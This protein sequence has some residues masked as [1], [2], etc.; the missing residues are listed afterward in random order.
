M[1]EKELC[2]LV[3]PFVLSQPRTQEEVEHFLMVEKN[4]SKEKCELIC[5]RLKDWF[6]SLE[7]RK[8][9]ATATEKKKD[10]ELEVKVQERSKRK[11]NDDNKEEDLHLSPFSKKPRYIN[12]DEHLLLREFLGEKETDFLSKIREGRMGLI[13]VIHGFSGSSGSSDQQQLENKLS[14]FLHDVLFTPSK[15]ARQSKWSIH[16]D[17]VTSTRSCCCCDSFYFERNETKG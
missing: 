13:I 12:S 11:I 9:M 16:M 10:S 2:L 8:L 4:V 6:Y 17:F 15:A 5:K 1:T 7:C 14:Q 3:I